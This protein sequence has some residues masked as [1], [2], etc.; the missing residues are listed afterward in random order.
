MIAANGKARLT[1][2]LAIYGPGLIVGAALLTL[3]LSTIDLPGRDF[4]QFWTAGRALTAG[5]SPYDQD[6]Q[7]ATQQ[8]NGWDAAREPIPFQPYFYPPWLAV[9]M[10]PLAQLPYRLALAAWLT[11]SLMATA[12]AAGLLWR[13]AQPSGRPTGLALA[14]LLTFTY[15][16]VLHALAVGQLN[17]MLLLLVALA[18]WGSQARRDKLAGVSLGL[19]A[20]KPQLGLIIALVM[21]VSWLRQRR[22]TAITWLLLTWAACGAA[23]FVV[24]PGWIGDMLAAPQ[25]FTDLTGWTFP[26]NGYQDDPTVF[27]ALKIGLEQAPPAIVIVITLLAGAMII[28][29]RRRQPDRSSAA[30]E[31]SVAACLLPFVLSPYA[32]V[33]DLTLLV[34]P[35]IYLLLTLRLGWPPPARYAAALAVYVWPLMLIAAGADGVWNVIA[36]FV[37][38]A[39]MKSYKMADTR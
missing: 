14:L 35:L 20:V 24:A 32:R 1:R 7:A 23:A 2:R 30:L 34:W 29:A 27:A 18:I 22:K 6:F 17:S 10:W 3:A 13:S 21:G 19:L 16:P 4:I 5:V 9:M 11:L 31:F 37:P 15:L 28:L 36:V 33:Y 38:A 26:L 8:A 25:R 12:L 39:A